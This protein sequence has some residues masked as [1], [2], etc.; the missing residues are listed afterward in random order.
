MT[1]LKKRR[2]IARLADEAAD[3]AVGLHNLGLSM[4]HD[5]CWQITAARV[6]EAARI[7][8]ELAA[9]ARDAYAKGYSAGQSQRGR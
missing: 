9:A 5:E 3:T 7:M 4:K 2:E 6:I 1:T 8:N